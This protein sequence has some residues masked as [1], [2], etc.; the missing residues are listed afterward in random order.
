M[1][2]FIE[3]NDFIIQ[4]NSVCVNLPGRLFGPHPSLKECCFHFTTD[5]LIEVKFTSG[6]INLLKVCDSVGSGVFTRLRP[7]ALA[8]LGTLVSSVKT[9]HTHQAAIPR[10]LPVDAASPLKDLPQALAS[11]IHK[12]LNSKKTNDPFFFK[13]AKDSN[14]CFSR[15]I[16][17]AKEHGKRGS[18]ASVI[19]KTHIETTMGRRFTPALMAFNFFG[20]K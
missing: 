18:T 12:E 2:K 4:E 11:R 17:V 20:G 16:H 13:R 1:N 3:R 9:S 14:R 10:S 7:T 5:V 19:R 15:D 6:M 8:G